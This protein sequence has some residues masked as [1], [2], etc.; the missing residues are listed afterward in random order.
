MTPS[1]RS[2]SVTEV[3][4]RSPG[5]HRLGDTLFRGLSTGSALL[6]LLVLAGVG[7]FLVVDGVGPT[8]T[9]AGGDPIPTTGSDCRPLAGDR[10][11]EVCDTLTALVDTSA[12]PLGEVAV[13][14]TNPDP[15]ACVTDTPASITV[16][17]PPSACRWGRTRPRADP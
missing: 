15:A 10:I 2:P 7:T 14:V 8:L 6:I 11:G 5:R 4:V 16:T 3:A 12:L 9:L 1:T 13:A 17:L